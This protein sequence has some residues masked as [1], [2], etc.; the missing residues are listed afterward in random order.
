MRRVIDGEFRELLREGH[1]R[2]AGRWG[3]G[4]PWPHTDARRRTGV[5]WLALEFLRER[6][7]DLDV[8]MP[9]E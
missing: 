5:T 2:D 8:R 9:S 4:V 1:L 6:Y 7:P 3:A